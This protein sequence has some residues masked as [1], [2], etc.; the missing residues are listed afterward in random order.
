MSI[1]DTLRRNIVNWLIP[2]YSERMA[3]LSEYSARR[4]Y[5][6]GAQRRP[7][8]VKPEQADDNL[9]LNFTGLIVDRGISMLF[10][11][12][13]EFD[14]GEAEE[15]PDGEEAA[16][17]PRNDYIDRVMKANT[18]P[19]FL[20]KTAQL[21]GTYGTAYVKIMPGAMPDGLPRLVAL[22][23][24]WLTLDAPPED[25]ETV[26]RYTIEYNTTD[27]NDK[28][29]T[30]KEVTERLRT[31]EGW[32][33]TWSVKSYIMREGTGGKFELV[34][35]VEWPYEFAPI[36]HWQNLPD[37][38]QCYGDSDIT[39]DMIAVQD[40]INFVASNVQRII[41]YHAH[42][43]T[44]G[45]GFTTSG[46]ASWGADEMV[47]VNGQDAMISNLE[48][49]SDLASSREF[50]HYLRGVMFDISRTVDLASMSD[51]LGALTNFALRVLYKDALDKLETKRLLYGWGLT[52][53]NR[54]LLLLAG[55]ATE[56]GGDV[57]WSEPLP[58]DDV[59]QAQALQTDLDMGI[60]DKETVSTIRGYDW[61]TVQERLAEQ[62]Q[63]GSNVGE[64]ILSDFQRGGGS[65]LLDRMMG[66]TGQDNV[67]A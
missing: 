50:L 35:D 17:D 9:I 16:T 62:E 44:W 4:D 38:E 46:T 48:M 2:E 12:G 51:K 64:R 32:A 67:I 6:E 61:E 52:E 24:Q 34:S 13:V 60:V 53:I 55:I 65:S 21:G 11:N 47:T 26:F 56:D 45:R 37:A 18:Y 27:E 63:S 33:D 20:H 25:M 42:P 39:D 57:V 40:A 10:G 8:K 22:N 28:E 14:F 19:I 58:I 15:T 3:R 29:I 7:L 30:R 36:V 31:T 54:R 23:P 41:R 66:T 59:G 43:K 49:S 5:R 1:T